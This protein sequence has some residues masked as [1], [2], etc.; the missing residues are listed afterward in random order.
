MLWLLS[1]ELGRPHSTANFDSAHLM[2]VQGCLAGYKYAEYLTSG[3]NPGFTSF[4]KD[5]FAVVP[6]HSNADTTGVA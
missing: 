2:T 1:H 6:Q 3:G 5:V 4:N